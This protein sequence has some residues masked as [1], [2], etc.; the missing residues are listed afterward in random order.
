MILLMEKIL[1]S[2]WVF[3]IKN[4]SLTYLK[5][6]GTFFIKKNVIMKNIQKIGGWRSG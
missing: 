3:I 6:Q 5:K 2:L 1:N 4:N